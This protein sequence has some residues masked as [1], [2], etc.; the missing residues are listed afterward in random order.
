MGAEKSVK[1][2]LIDLNVNP[3]DHLSVLIFLPRVPQFAGVSR[4]A[5]P[6]DR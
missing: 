4:N 5:V 1:V 6:V 3:R 2:G